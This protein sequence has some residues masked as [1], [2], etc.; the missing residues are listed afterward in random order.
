MI[1]LA[2]RGTDI[3]VPPLAMPSAPARLDEASLFTDEQAD[4][5]AGRGLV[6]LTDLQIGE[7]R[8]GSIVAGDRQQAMRIAASR[9]RGERIVG[10]MG[11]GFVRNMK[12][13]LLSRR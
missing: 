11:Q 1:A 9:E 6:Y 8:I 10:L 7:A 4:F 5:L 13:W 12:L 3:A 2:R